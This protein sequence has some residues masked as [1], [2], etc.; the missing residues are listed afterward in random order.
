MALVDFEVDDQRFEALWPLR[1]A[2]QGAAC[3]HVGADSVAVERLVRQ[4]RFEG[5][6]VDQGRDANRVEAVPRQQNEA[7]EVSERIRQREYLG[8]PA[9]LRLAYRMTLN[10]PFEPRP[11]Q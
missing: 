5:D 9:A 6:S 10:P 3:S 7:N 11:W 1:D 4:R 8:R 2:D